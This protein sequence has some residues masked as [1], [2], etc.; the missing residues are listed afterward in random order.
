VVDNIEKLL[1]KVN[2]YF[3]QFNKR[4]LELERL[5]SLLDVKGLKIFQNV[6]TWWFSTLSLMKRV[7]VQALHYVNVGRLRCM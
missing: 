6:E 4:A 2:F 7:L 5:D 3:F 1:I